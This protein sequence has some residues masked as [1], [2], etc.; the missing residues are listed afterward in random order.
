M[1]EV[2][3]EELDEI[4]I[5]KYKRMANNALRDHFPTHEFGNQNPIEVLAKALERTC[6]DLETRESTEDLKETHRE[7]MEEMDEHIDRLEGAINLIFKEAEQ[8]KGEMQRRDALLLKEH[9][10]AVEG[11]QE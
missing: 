4:E 9:N 8:I 11:K 7:E 10:D 6:E 3:V 5:A 2:E 1:A